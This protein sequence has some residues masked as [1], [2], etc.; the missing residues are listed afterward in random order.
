MNPEIL[1]EEVQNFIQNYSQPTATLAFAGSPFENITVQELIVQIEGRRKAEKKLPTWFQTSQIYYPKKLNIEQTS[2]EITAQYKASLVS[3]DSIADITGG[4]GVDSFYFSEKFKEISHFEIDTELSAIAAHNF[5]I[6]KKNTISC[7]AENGLQ[8][9]I[10]DEFDIIYV[11]PSRRHDEKGKVFFLK[12]CQ[13]NI[14]ENL[15]EILRN[16]NVLMIKTSPML[17]IAIGLK[18]LQYTFEIHIVAVENEVKE[19][20]WLLREEFKGNPTI[21]T[22]NLKKL[23]SE[24]FEF[25]YN[26]EAEANYSHPE[27]FLYEP[28]AAILKSGAFDLVS[29]RFK[30]NKLHKHTHLYTNKTLI[31]FPGRTFEIEKIVPYSK[32]EMKRAINF[33]KAN[34]ATRNFPESVESLQKKWKI[35]DGGDIYLFF[36]TDM[37]N[38]KKLLICSKVS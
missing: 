2:S 36:I 24:K 8:A 30:L 33:P 35:K 5:L 12:D 14:P 4:F 16:C 3:G 22:I 38:K 15:E 29:H 11:D 37:D 18:D 10:N 31:D 6:F 27:K 21:K 23:H 32:M 9:A 19:L 13:P 26:D 20:I 17:D 25:N 34:I 7:F 28:N 1:K